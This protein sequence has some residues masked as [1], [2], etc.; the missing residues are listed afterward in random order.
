MFRALPENSV[1]LHAPQPVRQPA[2]IGLHVHDFKLGWRSI[3]P[4]QI[5]LSIATIASN[6]W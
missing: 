1:L 3:T 4:N 2:G 5:R 6:G